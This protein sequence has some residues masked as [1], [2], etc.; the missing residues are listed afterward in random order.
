MS[1]R[2][3]LDITTDEKRKDL[4]TLFNTFKSKADIYRYFN[5]HDSS[6]NIKIL[7]DVAN[8]IGFDFSN[9][10]KKLKTCLCCGKTL[11]KGQHKFCSNSCS[12]K[13]NN[14]RRKIDP[15]NRLTKRICVVCGK[16]FIC[17]KHI[18]IDK[19]KCDDCKKHHRPYTKKT[20]FLLDYSKRTVMKILKRAG[21]GC[22]ICGWNEESCDVHHITPKSKGGSDENS[23]LIIV[24]PCCHRMCHNNRFTEDFL[25]SKSIE[26]TFKDWKD[27]YNLR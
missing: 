15:I 13:Y 11:S 20:K 22:E 12:A 10:K 27:F 5:E 25:R 17:S 24:C 23:N 16:E 21:R 3:K 14:V 1:L 19:C 26:N 2:D 4:L 7:N 8:E 6:S 18:K 9:Y